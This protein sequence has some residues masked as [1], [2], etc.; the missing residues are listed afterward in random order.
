MIFDP[1]GRVNEQWSHFYTIVPML[2]TYTASVL[3]GIVFNFIPNMGSRL[4][5]KCCEG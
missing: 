1:S 4:E 3:D 2:L 5:L